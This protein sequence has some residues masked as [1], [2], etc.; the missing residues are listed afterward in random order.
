MT[1]QVKA[2]YAALTS[3]IVV[4]VCIDLLRRKAWYLGQR[5]T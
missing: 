3:L 5:S 1:P 4:A 2:G